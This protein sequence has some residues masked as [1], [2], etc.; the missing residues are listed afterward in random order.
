VAPIY[1]LVLPGLYMTGAYL[2]RNV[3]TVSLPDD[4]V[5]FEDIVDQLRGDY[6]LYLPIDSLRTR[7]DELTGFP[8]LLTFHGRLRG[9]QT[10]HDESHQTRTSKNDGDYIYVPLYHPRTRSLLSDQS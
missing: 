2:T 4:G 10:L 3:F 1:E 5:L 8:F 6:N 7:I 9:Q